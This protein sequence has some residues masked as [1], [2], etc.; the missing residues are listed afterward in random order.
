MAPEEVVKLIRTQ[1]QVM[2]EDVAR[3]KSYIVK[4]LSGRA[5]NLAGMWLKEQGIAEPTRINIQ[6]KA[7]IEHVIRAYS[8]RKAFY[9]AVFEL[10]ASGDMILTEPVTKFEPSIGF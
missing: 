5:E 10:V 3:A 7:Q 9:Q 2:R 1:L 4:Q 8:L 6:D